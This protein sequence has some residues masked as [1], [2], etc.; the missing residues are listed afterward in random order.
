MIIEP[1]SNDQQPANDERL[2]SLDALR[3]F[4]MLLIIG[5]DHIVESLN[6]ASQAPVVRFFAQQFTHKQWEGFAFYD[7]IFPLFVFMVGVSLVYSLDKSLERGGAGSAV[8]RLTRRSVLLYLLGVFYNGGISRGIAKVRW[9]GVLQRIAISYFVAALIYL[10][11]RRS[12]KAVLVATIAILAAYWAIMSYVPMPGLE[13][14]SFDEGKNIANYIDQQ[15]LPGKK[16]DGQ[17]D[18]EGL[19]SSLPAVATCLLGVLAGKLLKNPSVSP[20]R[21]AA[22]LL[23][24]GAVLVPLGF[25]W[26]EQFPVIKKLW[27]SSYVLVAGGYSFLLLGGFYLVIDVWKFRRG[28][29]P[30]VWIGAN[31]L[32]MYLVSTIVSFPKVAERVVGGEIKHWFGPWDETFI[33]VVSLAL[34]GVAARFLYQRKI[35]LR[36]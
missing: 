15:Y 12:A 18:P 20:P 28:L 22:Y 1:M 14:V 21:K 7:L 8:A 30:L 27:T 35:F 9:M 17:W 2:M 31:A 4:D 36:V 10:V 16:Y 24:A 5:A 6:K 34:L 29:A 23:I 26:G 11:C 33:A 13:Q 32:T 25:W 3:G 19:L